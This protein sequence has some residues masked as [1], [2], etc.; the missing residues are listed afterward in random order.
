ML[1]FSFASFFV[2]TGVSQGPTVDFS[3][4]E[5]SYSTTIS[6]TWDNEVDIINHSGSYRDIYTVQDISFNFSEDTFTRAI[7]TINLDANY[8]YLLNTTLT[9]SLDLSMSLDVY[10][11][12][13]DYGT[14]LK[15]IWIAVKKGTLEM[16][17]TIVS[18]I[19]S[20]SYYEENHQIIE[21][22]YEKYNFT[23][24]ELLDTWNDTDEVFD[25]LNYTHTKNFTYSPYYK[26]QYDSSEF[27]MPLFLTMQIYTTEK[28][29]RIAWANL[30][31]DFLMYKDK[32]ENI[33][34]SVGDKGG[35]IDMWG[36]S[37]FCGYI[38][39]MARHLYLHVIYP[40]LAIDWDG[41]IYFPNDKT[42]ML[43]RGNLLLINHKQY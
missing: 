28:Q 29:D 40:E 18:H 16:E 31:H 33:I 34:Y 26:Y 43:K 39:P 6:R 12:D 13:I 25:E 5:T 1:T 14:G 27:T 21:S 24:Y 35:A 20:Y 36:S 23:T 11:V 4:Q 7:R 38:K 10:R 2:K 15:Y 19:Y 37:E 42:L 9:G 22:D 17:Y 32:D 8:S 41:Y 30:F 3:W